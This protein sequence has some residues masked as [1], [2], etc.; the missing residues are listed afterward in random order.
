MKPQNN[1]RTFFL[2]F[3]A[4]A[5]LIGFALAPA[6][7]QSRGK[8]GSSNSDAPI[9]TV[10]K[11]TDLFEEGKYAEASGY[12]EKLV[13]DDP[14]NASLRFL[15]GF[16]LMAKAKTID[17]KKDAKKVLIQARK[18][19]VKAKQ[20]G[21][22][23]QGIDK[24]IAILPEDEDDKKVDIISQQVTTQANTASTFS[25]NK[26]A[27]EY[28]EKG[29]VFFARG[30]YD[31]AFEMYQKALKKDPNLYEA[32]LWSGD[33]MMHK[34]EFDK[35]ESWYQKAIAINPNRETA[36]RYSATPLM[37]QK[38]FDEARLRY[39]EAY[40][41]EPYNSRAMGGLKQ[42]SEITG[43]EVGHPSIDVPS[44][45]RND[46]NITLAMDDR[47]DTGEFAWTLYSRARA[48]W[49][50]N[51]DGLSDSFKK[52]YPNETKYRH[53]LAE[54]FD[55]LRSTVVALKE[56]MSNPKYKDKRIDPQLKTL[57]RLYD[58]G[59]L[60]SY[61]LFALKDE[62]I[63]RDHAEYLKQN[64]EKLRQ[65]VLG[66]VVSKPAATTTEKADG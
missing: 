57:I 48:A 20:L 30:D 42:W 10:K 47:T 32:A 36:Y 29:E 7:A 56:M 61:I 22:K 41:T 54:E 52:A 5:V 37:K 19:L 60:E 51:K 38:K 31:K 43:V 39:V 50:S 44:N 66:Y 34:N 35:A 21:L 26:D 59:L 53:S 49:Q 62:G 58:E 40:I 33:V 27:Q 2:H 15:Y 12:L 8:D 45:I 46:V 13:K 9:D 65:Y 17:D 64:R 28:M 4:L 63:M 3:A 16:A 24:L 18:E 6:N 55:A 14:N 1:I 23:E 25:N 11:V